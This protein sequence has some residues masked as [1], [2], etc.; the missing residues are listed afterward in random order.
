MLVQLLLM[1]RI[2]AIKGDNVILIC[3][4]EFGLLWLGSKPINC[5][6]TS[7]SNKLLFMMRLLEFMKYAYLVSLADAYLVITP[8]LFILLFFAY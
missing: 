1:L 6:Y 3:E 4:L 7:L 8:E 5:S 2:R